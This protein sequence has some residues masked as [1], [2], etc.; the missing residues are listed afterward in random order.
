MR[1][2]DPELARSIAAKEILIGVDRSEVVGPRASPG[3]IA[4]TRS[5]ADQLERKPGARSRLLRHA[6]IG[7]GHAVG[8][9]VG[10]GHRPF[11][12]EEL[13]HPPEVVDQRKAVRRAVLHAGGIERECAEAIILVGN[14]AGQVNRGIGLP[15]AAVV[16][17][18]CPAGQ[19]GAGKARNFNPLTHVGAAVVIVKF[20][21]EHIGL[22]GNV[23][24]GDRPCAGI[25]GDRGVGTRIAEHH[26][27]SLVGLNRGIASHLDRDG[28]CQFTCG[29]VDR[30]GEQAR[31]VRSIGGAVKDSPGRARRAAGVTTTG[32]GKHQVGGAA[33]AFGLGDVI[34]AELRGGRGIVVGDRAQALLIG[35]SRTAGCIEQVDEENFV[36]FEGGIASHGDRNRRG[37]LAIREVDRAALRECC[38][39]GAVGGA[40]GQGPVGADRPRGAVAAGYGKDIVDRAGIALCLAHIVD[41]EGACRRCGRVRGDREVVDTQPVVRT[42]CVGI[43]P[44]DPERLSAGDGLGQG[45]RVRQR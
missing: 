33:V 38:K 8:R 32:H 13:D 12:A 19:I 6:D 43:N 7:A 16:E 9:A 45:Q 35:K 41:R 34:D 21:E 1:I 37:G 25:V 36:A 22:R 29:E 18:D 3:K 40:V 27:E 10:G 4:R 28:L 14:C 20:V 24:V 23:V 42:G 44:A 5:G 30:A 2:A 17:H 39:I 15:V 26:A 31:K 11:I